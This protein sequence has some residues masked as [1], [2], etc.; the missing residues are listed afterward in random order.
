MPEPAPGRRRRYRSTVRE[1]AKARTRQTILDT[2]LALPAE[3]ELEGL[4]MEQ[5]ARAA[6]VGPATLY[7]HFPNR[8]ALYGAIVDRLNE[9]TGT[10]RLPRAP[11]EIAAQV[12]SGFAEFDRMAPVTA[13]YL[14]SNF[15]REVHQVG[16]QRR[17][18]AYAAALEPVTSSL[19]EQERRRLEAS[20]GY[21][22][23]AR[24]WL[25]LREEFGMTG[26]E[27]GAAIGWAVRTLI[28]AA[29]SR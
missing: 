13:A 11:D 14:R 24:A 8:D 27:A 3:Q 28:Q 29:R 16:R 19:H 10:P 7:R 21:L 1:A 15:G 25:A 20:V 18:R 5:L 4:T 26:A 22:A 9:V 6:G 12:E 17:L 2:L 23:S